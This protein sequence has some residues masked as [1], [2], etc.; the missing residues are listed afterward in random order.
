MVGAILYL[1]GVCFDPRTFFP[2]S[3]SVLGFNFLHPAPFSTQVSSFTRPFIPFKLRE[4]QPAKE[5]AYAN[6]SESL[7]LPA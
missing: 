6:L 1:S 2:P 5:R 7:R 3:G 4:Y